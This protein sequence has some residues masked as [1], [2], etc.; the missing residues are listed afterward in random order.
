M[1]P[2]PT[3]AQGLRLRSAE[4]LLVIYFGYVAVIAPRFPLEQQAIWRPFLAE[5]LVLFAIDAIERLGTV[6]K[7]TASFANL[8]L[9][10]HFHD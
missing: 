10:A 9:H 2:P 6:P 8:Q 5:L 1:S 4:W 7:T 3:G